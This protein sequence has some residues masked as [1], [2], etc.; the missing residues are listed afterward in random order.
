M[1]VVQQRPAAIFA[2]AD[3]QHQVSGAAVVTNAALS[4]QLVDRFVTSKEAIERT[5]VSHPLLHGLVIAASILGLIGALVG[6]WWI[7]QKLL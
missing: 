7:K 5:V 3:P 2:G 6:M 1:A 4:V